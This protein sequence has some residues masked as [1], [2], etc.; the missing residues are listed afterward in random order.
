MRCI[1]CAG[2]TI[3][4]QPNKQPIKVTKKINKRKVGKNE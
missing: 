3:D 1:C 2:V 4:K